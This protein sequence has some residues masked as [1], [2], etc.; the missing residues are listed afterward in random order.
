MNK[1][2]RKLLFVVILVVIAAVYAVFLFSSKTDTSSLTN[3][4]I[5][6]I[7]KDEKEL[8]EAIREIGVARAMELLVEESKG[9]TI[10]DC[11]QEAHDIGRTGYLEIKEKAFSE[12]DANCHS[13]C[14]H[15]A[16]EEFLAEKGTV[17]IAENVNSVCKLFDTSFGRFECL[18]GVGHGLMA[19]LNY[20]MEESILA[21]KE[22]E[23]WFSTVSCYGGMFMENILTGQGLGAS[24][25]GHTTTWLSDDP[26]FPCN[27]ID[28]ADY[29]LQYQC[30]QMQTSWMLEI[31]DYDFNKVAGE[32]LNARDDMVNVCYRSYGRDAAGNSL[33]DPEK[34]VSLC[35]K[36]PESS[37]SYYRECII[38]GMNV[39]VDFWGPELKNQAN[40]L[41]ALTP[42]EY[43]TACYKTLAE[44]IKSLTNS[45]SKQREICSTFESDYKDLCSV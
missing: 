9:G 25:T 39:I 2:Y 40:E 42:N 10:Y 41:C 30:Y 44:R 31:Y 21:C 1:S 27:G 26:H 28:S 37:S 20:D 32:C 8:S 38:G 19:Y 35:S 15:G 18:H 4:T 11:H 43:K 36:V 7:S 6:E 34:I 3:K 17:N 13:G 16:M 5:T 12:C 29:D 24:K 22:L 23:D 33:R 45:P 14:Y